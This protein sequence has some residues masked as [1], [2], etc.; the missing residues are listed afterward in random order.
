M[1]LT[2][3][4]DDAHDRIAK[5]ADTRAG[6]LHGCFVNGTTITAASAARLF[7]IFFS[8][9]A[10]LGRECMNAFVHANALTHR[11]PFAAIM[12]GR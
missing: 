9:L 11:V 12:G 10:D 5:I 8:I 4:D 3:I 1:V 2:E 6:K 7:T